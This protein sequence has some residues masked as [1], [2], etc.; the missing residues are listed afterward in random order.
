MSPRHKQVSDAFQA[1]F[2]IDSGGV[3][4]PFLMLVG[5]LFAAIA[6]SFQI[7]IGVQRINS[8]LDNIEARLGIHDPSGQ[9]AATEAARLVP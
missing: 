1:W 5:G 4:L 2:S 3:R 8:R 7:G 9:A 6:L